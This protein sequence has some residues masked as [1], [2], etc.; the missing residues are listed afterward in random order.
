MYI[1]SEEEEEEEKKEVE[2]V[3]GFCCHS[4][5]KEKELVPGSVNK[6][7]MLVAPENPTSI[8]QLLSSC[9][10]ENKNHFRPLLT[11]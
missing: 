11:Y 1:N 3:K 4:L 8:K 6:K 2:D 10:K 5:K 7:Q 9:Q